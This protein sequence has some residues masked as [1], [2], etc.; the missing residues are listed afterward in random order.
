MKN[1]TENN[2]SSHNLGIEEMNLTP[3]MS[4]KINAA[5]EKANTK[6]NLPEGASVGKNSLRKRI[7]TDPNN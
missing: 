2:A 7:V 4:E 6:I 5:F 1:Y 3:S